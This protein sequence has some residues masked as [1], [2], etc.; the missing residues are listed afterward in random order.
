VTLAKLSQQA[1]EKSNADYKNLLK[2]ST[3]SAAETYGLTQKS[4]NTF[5]LFI[6]RSIW[7]GREW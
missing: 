2:S 4:F 1:V 7:N 3:L 5:R 6:A